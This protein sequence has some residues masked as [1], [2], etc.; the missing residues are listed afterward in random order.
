MGRI[1]LVVVNMIIDGEVLRPELFS[2]ERVNYSWVLGGVLGVMYLSG[3]LLLLGRLGGGVSVVIR[4]RGEI[5]MGVMIDRFG[6]LGG[7]E[8]CFRL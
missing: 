4:V 7:D 1:W 8:E 3:K 6:L 2:K 5:I